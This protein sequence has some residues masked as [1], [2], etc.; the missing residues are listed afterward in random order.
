MTGKECGFNFT[1]S[2]H[3]CGAV[4]PADEI[5]VYNKDVSK[6]FGLPVGTAT[7]HIRYC[8]DNPVCKVKAPALELLSKLGTTD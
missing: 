3:V 8:H 6:R 7:L 2:C 1:F 4:R 5:E